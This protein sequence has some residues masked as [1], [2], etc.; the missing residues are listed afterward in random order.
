MG[1]TFPKIYNVHF[2]ALIATLGGT[3][4]G[5][6]ISSIAAIVTSQ[7][8]LTFFNHPAGALQGAIGSALAAGSV[9]G[10]AVAGP[11]SDKIGRRDSIFVAVFFWLIGT[12]V[13][14]AAQNSGTLIAG[15]VINGFT[16]GVTSAQVPVYLAEIAKAE[17]RGSL[18][19]VQQLAIEFGILVMY[20]IGYGC[21]FIE[22]TASFRTAW[23]TQFIPAVFLL[24]GLPFLPRSPRWLA[25]VGRDEEAILTLARIQANGDINDPLVIAEWEEISTV[26]RAE[27]ET[28]KG[29]RKFIKNGMWKRTM[30]G[31]SVQAWQQLAGANVIVYYLT[32][33]AQMAGLT[34]NVGMVTSGVQYAVFIIFTGVMWLFIDKTGRRTLLVYGALGMGF[35][36]FVIGGVMAAHHYDVPEGIDNNP[37]VIFAVTSGAPANTVIVFSYLLI[38]VYALTLAP[39]CWIYAAEVWSLG[40]RATGMSLAALSN[41]VFNFALGMF[42]PPGFV[43]IKYNLFIVFG[44][45]CVAASA[46]F[47]AFYPETCG[48]TLEEIE[49]LFGPDGPKPWKTKKGES[50]LGAEIQAV[51]EKHGHEQPVAENVEAKA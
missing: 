11:L 20:F 1:I 45:L 33:I 40:T 48:K 4:F 29:W 31:M 46:W 13:Q 32:Y 49:I 5:F 38:V 17:K 39:V 15:R 23:G 34:G 10:S 21:T 19:I 7:Q 37:N 3:L 18:V 36:H 51:L 42:T 27:R 16:V 43:N 24:I 6:D 9:V 8:Y 30:A 12:S 22:G 47:F 2:V 35:C 50:R 28:G 44:V 26:L 25:K 14:V 41:W